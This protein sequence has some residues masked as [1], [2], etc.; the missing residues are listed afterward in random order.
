[1]RLPLLGLVFV[2]IALVSDTTWVVVAGTAR[3]WFAR[4]LRRLEVVGAPA[5]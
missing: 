3:D 1:M 2:A 4:S 5:G